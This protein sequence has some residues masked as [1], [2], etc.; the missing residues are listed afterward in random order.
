[1]RLPDPY[2]AEGRCRVCRRTMRD[3]RQASGNPFL[4]LSGRVDQVS[5]NCPGQPSPPP[6]PDSSGAVIEATRKSRFILEMKS[7]LI[8][9]GQAS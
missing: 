3:A 6:R 4:V 2:S 7:M 8:S 5:V 1:M 9:F